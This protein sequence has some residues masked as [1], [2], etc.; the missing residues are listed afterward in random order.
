MRFLYLLLPICLVMAFLPS[1]ATATS[2]V[3]TANLTPYPGV[4]SAGSGIGEVDVSNDQQTIF[5]TLFVSGLSGD[6]DSGTGLYNGE[7]GSLVI[8]LNIPFPSFTSGTL[9]GTY[10]LPTGALSE[11]LAGQLF[12]VVYT[13]QFGG[14]QSPVGFAALPT[15]IAPELAGRVSLAPEPGTVGMLGLGLAAL[16]CAVRRRAKSFC[17]PE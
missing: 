12:F 13:D 16:G 11:L 3:L 14:G 8:P 9:S 2:F 4:E 6:V 7:F 5:A 1:Q 10:F 17:G 15:V